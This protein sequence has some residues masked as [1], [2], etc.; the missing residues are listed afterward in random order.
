MTLLISTL[1]TIDLF[2]S[3]HA[4]GQNQSGGQQ[5]TEEKSLPV[6]LIHCHVEEAAVW[7]E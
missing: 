5:Q 6:L 7:K 3:L 2:V 1:V 4:F